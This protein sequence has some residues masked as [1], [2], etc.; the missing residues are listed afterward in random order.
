M[1]ATEI[2][3]KKAGVTAPTVTKWIREGRIPAVPLPRTWAI[4]EAVLDHILQHG[5]PA[6]DTYPCPTVHRG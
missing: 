6:K 4:A 2:L 5:V 1:L 3:A